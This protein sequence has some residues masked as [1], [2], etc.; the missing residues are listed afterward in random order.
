MKIC[1]QWCFTSQ[2]TTMLWNWCTNDQFNM[3]WSTFLICNNVGTILQLN[4]LKNI[5]FNGN[6]FMKVC[7]YKKTTIRNSLFH[8]SFQF[9]L[10]SWSSNH[11]ILKWSLVHSVM[12][13][14]MIMILFGCKM[15]FHWRCTWT[16]W[17]FIILQK[18]D[19][20]N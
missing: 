12:I 18:V 8:Q 14:L 9:V 15:F 19:F 10:K 13:M 6:F 17:F 7:M 3:R 16:K 20:L 2:S 1:N 5:N 11:M 4:K